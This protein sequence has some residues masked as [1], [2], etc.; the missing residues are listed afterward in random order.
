MKKT[1]GVYGVVIIAALSA[2]LMLVLVISSV[3]FERTDDKDASVDP[4]QNDGEGNTYNFLIMGKDDAADLCDVIIIASYD[5]KKRTIEA[6]QIPRDTYAS[7][8]S[9][10]Y[11]KLNGAVHSLGGVKEFAGFLEKNLGLHI[12]YYAVTDLDTIARAV[13]KIGGVKISIDEDMHYSDPYQN[14]FIDLKAGEHL[15]NGEESNAFLRYR[16]GYVQGDI[17]RL[18]AQKIFV[19][20]LAEKLITEVGAIEAANLALL[21]LNDIDTNLTPKDCGTLLAG[22]KDIELENI[23]FFTI[24]GESVQTQGGA[25][26]YVINKEQAFNAIKT[27]FSPKLSVESFD[28]DE[29]F[30]SEYQKS[31]N[32]IYN[33]RDVYKIKRYSAKDICQNGIKID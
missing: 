12:D 20:A 11:R 3:R 24:P 30:T 16:S 1:K 5:T 29:L 28:S 6:M 17:G 18:D 21:F 26:Y 25:W 4:Y 22:I 23:S 14:L 19:A 13:D 7:Y 10:S 27:Y 9:S 8:T 15:L 31:F 33:A 32:R 2:I